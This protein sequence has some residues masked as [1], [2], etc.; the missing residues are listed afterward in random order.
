MD[1]SNPSPEKTQLQDNEQQTR[2]G[3]ETCEA[4]PRYQ[5]ST[6]V[7]LKHTGMVSEP[8]SELTPTSV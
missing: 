2:N 6:R 7:R 4:R 3:A 1:T 8:L 5:T